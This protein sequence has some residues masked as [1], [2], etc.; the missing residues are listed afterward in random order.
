MYYLVNEMDNSEE[1][2]FGRVVSAHRT[3]AA[4][5]RADARLQRA[6][7]RANGGTSYLPTIV[8]RSRKRLRRGAAVYRRDAERVEQSYTDAYGR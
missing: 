5:W 6:V 7:K 2:A 1:S 3:A 4:A 8:V